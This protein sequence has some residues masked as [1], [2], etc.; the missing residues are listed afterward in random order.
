MSTK[1]NQENIYQFL[2]SPDFK[3]WFMERFEGGKL[4]RPYQQFMYS[5]SRFLELKGTSAK[6]HFKGRSNPNY[7]PSF[8]EYSNFLVNKTHV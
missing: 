1:I 5:F 8:Y 2:L 6:H 4:N 7:P 3:N